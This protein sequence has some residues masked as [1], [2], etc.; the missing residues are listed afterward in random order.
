MN[1][2]F[3]WFRLVFLS[4]TGVYRI[5]FLSQPLVLI[6]VQK[7]RW[8]GNMTIRQ[9]RK[10]DIPHSTSLSNFLRMLTKV[11][12]NSY[13]CCILNIIQI[14]E[15]LRISEEVVQIWRQFTWTI[16]LI[17]LN[18]TMRKDTFSQRNRYI[19]SAKYAFLHLETATLSAKY[20]HSRMICTFKWYLP[21]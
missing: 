18:L 8:R 11:S 1:G 3:S 19:F 6:S 15:I 4:S 16:C 13:K 17:S 5:A 9:L 14:H 2:A 10:M 7:G 12:R 20:E 21:Y